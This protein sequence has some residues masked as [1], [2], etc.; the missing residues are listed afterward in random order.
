MSNVTAVVAREKSGAFT[1]IELLVVIAIIGILAA[2]L[3]PALNKAREKA[4]A[5]NCVSNMHQW[6]LAIQMYCDEFTEYY[7]FDGNNTSPCHPDNTWAWYN[8]LTPY[9]SHPKLCDLYNN[10]EP[11]R[12]SGKKSIFCCPSATLRSVQPTMTSPI[13]WYGLSTCLHQETL[14]QIGFRRDRMVAPAQT[15]IFCE[16]AEDNFGETNGR[17]ITA[18]PTTPGGGIAVRHSGGANFVMGD[19]HVEWIPFAKFCRAGNAGCPA[20]LVNIEWDN[21]SAGG[22]WKKG[23]VEYHWWF[24]QNANTSPF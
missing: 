5:A 13:F 9:I 1:L 21:S 20:P 4:N 22:D 17:Y 12:P 7:P 2:M 11:P 24:F 14:T 3:L 15:I 23:V 16:V 18:T 19:G 8:V 6:S 10:N